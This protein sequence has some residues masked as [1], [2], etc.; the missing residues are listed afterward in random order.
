MD[1]F[2]SPPR[3][4]LDA[5]LRPHRSLSPRG[6]L[7]LLAPVAAMNLVSAV[8]F[9][10]IGAVV[11]PPFLGLDVLGLGLAF[12][13]SFRGARASERVRVSADEI[14][15]ELERA[16]AIRT[17]WTSAPAFTRLSLDATDEDSVTVRLTC[18]GRSV[19]LAEALGPAER[20]AFGVELEAALRA[21]RAER[22]PGA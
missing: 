3:L 18:K 4:Y 20:R 16:G 15:V 9:F 8:F 11:V 10:V 19:P 2:S 22:W 5:R 14:L 13:F 7:W 6:A 21:A 1:A 12:W 17:V